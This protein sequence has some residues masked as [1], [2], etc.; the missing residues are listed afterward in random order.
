MRINKSITLMVFFV[1]A[2]LAFDLFQYNARAQT[3]SG[4]IGLP[5]YDSGWTS[6]NQGSATTFTHNL[7]TQEI[8]VYM[9]GKCPDQPVH[10]AYYGGFM[11]PPERG[12]R[13]YSMD[14]NSITVYHGNDDYWHEVRVMIWRIEETPSPVS[15]VTSTELLMFLG[16]GLA[17]LYTVYNK[18]KPRFPKHNNIKQRTLL[19]Y[20]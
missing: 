1:S 4:S 12:A 20:T 19:E 5:A 13:W 14:A 9:I 17:V 8:F 7:G 18:I 15:E 6:I 3:S 11:E 16:L 10:Q 2:I